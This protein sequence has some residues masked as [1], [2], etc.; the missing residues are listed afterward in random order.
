MKSNYLNHAVRSSYEGLLQKDQYPGYFINIEIDPSLIDINVSPT[1]TEIKFE[2]E[3]LVYNY[4]KVATK[5]ALGVYILSP[6]IDFDS[7]VNI[8]TDRNLDRQSP[9]S[10]PSKSN[11][12]RVLSDA[13][14]LE[15]ENL[16]SW[17]S[18]YQGLES[19]NIP[20]D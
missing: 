19:Q 15:Q 18:I 14:K 20:K 17:H 7:N 16:K 13:Q 2:D 3:R 10:L 5:H 8:S 11:P 12:S 6:T 4:L 1:K 9:S